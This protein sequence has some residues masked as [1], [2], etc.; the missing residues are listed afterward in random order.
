MILGCQI[1]HTSTRPIE[2][3]RSAFPPFARVRPP[4]RAKQIA[5]IIDEVA[6]SSHG[7]MLIGMIGS[8]MFLMST[9]AFGQRNW[10]SGFLWLLVGIGLIALL[11]YL[12]KPWA[13]LW[14]VSE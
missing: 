1:T 3:A 13:N 5:H 2:P 7:S 14:P 8:V 4:A 6:M 12:D 9:F 11:T 10:K